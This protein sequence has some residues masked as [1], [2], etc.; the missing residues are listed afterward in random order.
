M[1]AKQKILIIDDE[2][3]ILLFVKYNL[4]KDG[5]D[6]ITSSDAEQGLE[7][8][9]KLKPDLILLDVM[10]PKMDGIEVC[11]ELRKNPEFDNTIIAFFTAR[12]EY[13]SQIEGFK[14]GA[15]AYLT[16]PVQPK[17]LIANLKA[18]LK[19]RSIDDS[20]TLVETIGRI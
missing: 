4:E 11:Q 17:L 7:L 19:R 10:M 12:G 16:K 5:F 1:E 20:E 6:V 14:S 2:E 8:A 18:L 13:Y 9:K 15:D 3:D